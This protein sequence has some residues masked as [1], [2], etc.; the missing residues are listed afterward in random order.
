M[1]ISKVIVWV[2]GIILL[3][4]VIFFHT[5][6]G[7][8]KVFDIII[9]SL[10]ESGEPGN[11]STDGWHT[12]Q[13]DSMHVEIKYPAGYAVREDLESPSGPTTG[14]RVVDTTSSQDVVIF[15]EHKSLEEM[16]SS[17]VLPRKSLKDIADADLT[18]VTPFSIDGAEGYR[19]TFSN[20]SLPLTENRIFINHNGKIYDISFHVRYGDFVVPASYSE[21]IISSLHWTK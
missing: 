18:D 8:G 6:W 10:E 17:A 20:E 7:R 15:V 5:E 2:L 3:L 1:K 12:Y 16:A 13:N 9:Y 19:G 14:F 11:I 21:E 4:Y